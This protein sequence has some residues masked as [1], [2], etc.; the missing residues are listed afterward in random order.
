M[1]SSVGPSYAYMP[2]GPGIASYHSLRPSLCTFM[3]TAYLAAQSCLPRSGIDNLSLRMPVWGIQVFKTTY[4]RLFLQ[5]NLLL[6]NISFPPC[7]AN[8]QS[9]NTDR[10][11]VWKTRRQ[12]FGR[13]KH[14][15]GL[16]VLEK[17]LECQTRLLRLP[18]RQAARTST[19]NQILKVVMVA[20]STEWR[21]TPGFVR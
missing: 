20:V 2:P 6:P 13:L 9:Q 18:C 21:I 7:P 1:S 10:R 3:I 5:L 8:V 17:A 19:Q 12:V 11:L 4:V 16:P 14:P 15:S